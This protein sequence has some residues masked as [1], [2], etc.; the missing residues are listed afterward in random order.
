ME[1]LTAIVNGIQATVAR[2]ALLAA[3]FMEEQDAGIDKVFLASLKSYIDTA[4]L[5]F[6]ATELSRASMILGNLI[7][8]ELVEEPSTPPAPSP[9][10][11]LST[12]P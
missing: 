7:P 5:K 2:V 3:P 8:S 10:P 9:R 11:A 6:Q 12:E 1:E 4:T